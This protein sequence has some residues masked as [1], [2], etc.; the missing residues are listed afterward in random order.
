MENYFPTAG[1]LNTWLTQESAV[2]WPLKTAPR[3]IRNKYCRHSVT[4][5]QAA[6]AWF[7]CY[8]MILPFLT[9]YVSSQ[10]SGKRKMPVRLNK[11]VVSSGQKEA[12]PYVFQFSLL[13]CFPLILLFAS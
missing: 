2:F 4:N 1:I 10:S 6:T 11:A 12:F 7:E 9:L 3:Q 13:D 8:R 5:V